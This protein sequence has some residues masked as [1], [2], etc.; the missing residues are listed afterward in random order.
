MNHAAETDEYHS[1]VDVAVSAAVVEDDESV[2]LAAVG[3]ATV[4]EVGLEGPLPV[5][6]SSS[7]D[8]AEALRV[9]RSSSVRMPLR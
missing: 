4:V 7:T 3:A 2:E 8:P 5:T 6:R 9:T 1:A